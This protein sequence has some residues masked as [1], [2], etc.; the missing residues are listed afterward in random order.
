MHSVIR[1]DLEYIIS[2]PLDWNRLAGKTVLIAGA[3]GFLPAY[4]VETLL[5]LNDTLGLNVQIIA[6][7][8][9]LE[10]AQRRFST[11]AKREDLLMIHG[12]VSEP[13]S[14]P[15]SCHFIIHAASQASPK[16]YGID[17]VGTMAANL[18]GTFHLLGQAHVWR[19]ECFLYFSSSE[20][21]GE[22]SPKL[23]PTK[24]SDYGYT[25]ITNPRSCYAES[26]RAAETLGVS[27]A[28][29]HGVPFKV[30]RPF[31]TYG[32][33]M[34]LDDGRV[35]ADFVRDASTGRN[36]QLRS[37][38]KAIRAFC[39]LSDAVRGF[40]TVLLH[41]SAAG[42]YNVGNPD[43]ALSIAELAGLVVSLRPELSLKVECTSRP[44][45]DY[46]QSP[47]SINIPNIDK[48][49]QLGWVPKY[50]PREGFDRT[51]RYFSS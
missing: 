6:L 8:R 25:D 21:Y 24:E 45:D 12:D 20:V 31:H 26:K 35:F 29:Q 22:V 36:L 7:V 19:S 27:F 38:G 30:V 44:S 23:V 49:K 18:L 1:E 33:G 9:N 17:P 34:A 13:Q 5:Y 46:V 41:E 47:I 51:L 37:D 10:K 28:T 3:A 16:F 14:W 43:G 42:A 2:M 32:P 50:S 39:Y 4:I 11:H 40:F 15:Q 48:L